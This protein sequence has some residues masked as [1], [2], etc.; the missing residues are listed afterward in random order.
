MNNK[1][2]INFLEITSNDQKVSRLK[3]YLQVL[4]LE[5]YM[6]KFELDSHGVL[7]DCEL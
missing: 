1:W 7:K 5:G 3:L 4:W 6:L 2:N